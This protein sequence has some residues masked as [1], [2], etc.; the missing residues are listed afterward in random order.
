MGESAKI[1]F[2]IAVMF[3]YT[4]SNGHFLIGVKFNEFFW[5]FSL[6]LHISLH[7]SLSG[8]SIARLSAFLNENVL[9]APFHIHIWPTSNRHINQFEF[10]YVRFCRFLHVDR[11]LLHFFITLNCVYGVCTPIFSIS[12]IEWK[13]FFCV[14]S[15]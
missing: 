7:A 14:L 13:Y 5:T 15:N 12:D 3:F 9:R 11:V 6:Y 4:R 1:F 2:R 10:A 8:I